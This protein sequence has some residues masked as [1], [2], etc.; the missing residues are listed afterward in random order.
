MRIRDIAPEERH[1]IGRRIYEARTSPMIWRD[2]VRLV[3]NRDDIW[4]T[5]AS[6]IAQTIARDYALRSGKAWPPDCSLSR[7]QM[8]AARAAA[9]AKPPRD[10]LILTDQAA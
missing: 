4:E 5:E 7:D 9:K 6:A 2:A 1:E 10:W 8:K 3:L